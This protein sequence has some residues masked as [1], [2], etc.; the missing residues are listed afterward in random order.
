MIRAEREG[1]LNAGAPPDCSHVGLHAHIRAHT[2][3][4]TTGALA[5]SG[6]QVL[7]LSLDRAVRVHSLEKV[8]SLFA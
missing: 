8:S 6:L 7:P 1:G 5:F 2:H 3:T 4:R